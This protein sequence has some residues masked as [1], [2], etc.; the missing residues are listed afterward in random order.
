MLRNLILKFKESTKISSKFFKMA[1]SLAQ[2]EEVIGKRPATEDHEPVVPKKKKKK[3][4][5]PVTLGPSENAKRKIALLVSYNGAG[6]YGVQI[7]RGFATIESELF[8]AL[9]KIGAIQPDHAETPSKM[10]FQRG[11]RTDK[12]VSA[13]GQTFSLKAKLVPD[14]VQKM[15]E[16]LPE[17]IRIMGYIRTTNA[18]DSKNFCCSRTYMY[19]MPT[20]SFA[21]VEKFIT[22]EYR[23]GPEIIERVR[24][25]LKRFLGTH[26]FH[27][28]TSGVKFSD[29]CASRY[30][31]KFECSDP[32]VRDGVEFVTLHV[33][34]QSFMLHQIRK[35][36]GITIAIVR[37]YCGENVIDKCWGPVQVDVPK[38]PGLG[39]VLEELHF[40]GYNK[41]FGCDGI[42]DPIDWTPFRESQ[43]KF[44]EEHIISDIVA[45]EKEDRVMFNWMRTLQFHNFGEPRSEGSEKPWANVARMLR[46]KSSPPPTEQTTDTAAQEDGEPPIVGDSAACEV[47]DSTN[48]TVP[49]VTI[50]TTVSEGTTDVIH[51]STPVSPV[52]ADTEPRSES[53]SDLSAESASR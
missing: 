7:N 49:E 31:I 36:I 39:L 38:A 26:K 13:V 2:A 34:G 44:K 52:K 50:D 6:Y 29:A 37:G 16:N 47:K 4:G 48:S 10:W 1:E 9:V 11:S 41:K 43:E 30:M 28:F 14:F 25:V 22:N 51:N 19:M 46:E 18:F 53:T 45:Q 8:P 24:E 23:T 12:G 17:K 5:Q 42:H 33:K 3:K 20:F 35:M 40:D 27:N 21:P 32:Y 15:N